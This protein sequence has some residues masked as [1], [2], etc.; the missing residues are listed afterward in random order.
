MYDTTGG[1]SPRFPVGEGGKEMLSQ[2]SEHHTPI[3]NVPK[4]HIVRL[5][6]EDC[7]DGRANSW[8]AKFKAALP[9]EF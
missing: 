8:G 2:M 5:Q 3:T 4:N 9:S 6:K 1:N 7:C